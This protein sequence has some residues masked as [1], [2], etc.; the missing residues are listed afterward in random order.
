[1]TQLK[2]IGFKLPPYDKDKREN[3]IFQQ[4]QSHADQIYIS[5]F[6]SSYS[7]SPPLSFFIHLLSPKAMYKNK[8]S[9][10]GGAFLIFVPASE[11]ILNGGG[12]GCGQSQSRLDMPQAHPALQKNIIWRAHGSVRA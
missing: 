11:R 2:H 6:S 1:M 12:E 9:S 7:S 5:L 4:R 3:I 8:K 10:V